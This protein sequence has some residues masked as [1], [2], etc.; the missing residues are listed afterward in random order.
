MHHELRL[1]RGQNNV[2]RRLNVPGSF[3]SSEYMGM[4]RNN[5]YCDANA[6]F[7]P[8]FLAYFGLPVDDVCVQCRENCCFSKC[9]DAFVPILNVIGILHV[10]CVEFFVVSF[11]SE[12]SVHLRGGDLVMPTR[13]DLFSWLSCRASY[14]FLSKLTQVDSIWVCH[15]LDLMS[16]FWW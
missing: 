12:P 13:F 2:H 10:D 16:I 7:P 5:R 9:V 11:L 4:S 8:S 3:F 14:S 1:S 6:V 15:W